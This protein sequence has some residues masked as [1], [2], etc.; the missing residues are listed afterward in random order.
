M[1][2]P[3]SV[4]LSFLCFA[5]LTMLAPMQGGCAAARTRHA[6]PAALVEAAQVP[7]LKG[8]RTWGDQSD[9]A[10]LADLLDSVRQEEAYHAAHP[11]T[12]MAPTVDILAISG[13]GEE[14]AFGAGLSCGWTD[15][16]DRP[17]FKLVTGISTGAL[18]APFV[19][20]GPKYDPVLRESYTQVTQK[21]IFRKRS[22]L[23]LLSADS[24]LDPSPLRK[25]V[26][27][28]VD[29]QL[30]REV[31]AEHRKG[32]RLLIATTNLDAQ[33]P[34]I[35]NMGAIADSGHPEAL[36]LFQDV[37]IASA[38]IPGAFPPVYLRVE[39]DGK[40]YDEMHVD[41]GTYVQVFLYGPSLTRAVAR[42]RLGEKYLGR[43]ARLYVIRNDVVSPLWTEVAAKLFPI[44]GRALSTLLKANGLN[45]LIRLHMMALRDDVDFNLASI[46]PDK[47][48]APSEPFDKAYMNKLFDYA[49]A[50]AKAGYPWLKSPPNALVTTRPAQ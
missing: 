47:F 40:P 10:F 35:W 32:R 25:L 26:E 6:V 17:Q 20:A 39:A 1:S 38:S 22:L 48:G 43:P 33:R 16:G 46:P 42:Q 31:A 18:I 3:L 11:Q 4:G 28:T 23:A 41:G 14:G 34:V 45:D 13:G 27:R 50:Q 44:G 30:V 7:G 49:Y 24:L 5:A 21:D 15:A 12:R 19:F 2:R 37:M 9:E 36:R 29:E 8:I